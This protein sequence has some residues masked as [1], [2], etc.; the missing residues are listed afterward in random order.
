MKRTLTD[1]ITD[2]ERS[3]LPWGYVAVTFIALVLTRNLLEGALGPKGV[4]GFVYFTS[5]STLMVLD[6]FILFYT[7]LFLSF[8]LVL[9]TLARE[10][11]GAVMRVMT[12]AWALLL[13][14]PVL[15][16]IITSGEGIKITYVL[17][18]R[19]VILRFFDPGASELS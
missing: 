15:D 10:R 2:A 6:H 5:P 1:I 14:P 13:L 12:P 11:V 3:S 8:A 18:L 16:Y 4:I 19:P 9:S 17:D 7:S